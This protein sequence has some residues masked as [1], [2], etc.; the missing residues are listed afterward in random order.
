MAV[1]RK[2]YDAMIL[3]V[4]HRHHHAQNDSRADGIDRRDSNAAVED[5]CE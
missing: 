4:S 1:E 2:K 5:W 3:M